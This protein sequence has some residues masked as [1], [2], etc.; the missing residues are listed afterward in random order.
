M[1]NQTTPGKEKLHFTYLPDFARFLLEQKFEVY[2][3]ELLA[4]YRLV[5]FPVMK[6][7]DFMG[8]EKVRELCRASQTKVLTHIRDNKLAAYFEESLEAWRDNQLPLL[9]RDEV[10]AEDISLSS[11]IRKK[12][13]GQFLS[14]YTND[15]NLIIAILA[16]TDEYCLYSET[17]SLNMLLTIQREKMEAANMDLQNKEEQLLQAQQ[18]AN[19]G[20]FEWDLVGKDTYFSPGLQQIF[21]TEAPA[22]FKSFLDYVH[23]EDRDKVNSALE[24][25]L[26]GDGHYECEYRYNKS[27]KEKI[28]WSRGIVSFINGRAYKMTG[29]VAD[30]TEIRLSSIRLQTLNQS[31]LH[32][33]EMLRRSEERNQKMVAE[34]QDY[35]I[36]TLDKNGNVQNWNLGAEKIKGYNADEIIGKNFRIF[37]RSGDIAKDLPGFLLLQ[38]IQNGRATNE[39]YRVRKDGSTFWA[40]VVITALHNNEGE[41]IGFSKVTRD[42]TD[43]KIA[44]DSL[45]KYAAQLKEREENIRHLIDNAP[46]AVVVINSTGE[47]TLWNPEATSIFGWQQEEMV[48]KNLVETIIAPAFRD[49]L[50]YEITKLLTNDDKVRV[51]NTIELLAHDRKGN[52]IPV[53]FTVSVSKQGEE[54]IF[55]AFIRNISEEKRIKSELVRK[56]A[57]LAEL[58]QAL[59]QKN[60]DLEYN[61]QELTSFSYVASHDLQEPLRKIKTFSN[62]IAESETGNMSEKGKELF[63]RINNSTTRMQRL[64]DDLLAFSR[65]HTYNRVFEDVDLN[66]VLTEVK[67]AVNDIVQEPR[68]I[69]DSDKLPVIQGVHFQFYQIFENLIG[70]SLKYARKDIMPRVRIT[71]NLVKGQSVAIPGIDPAASFCEI[72]F[73]DNGIGFE[74][75]HANK[76]F[77]IFQRLHSK[78]EYSGTGIG[79]AICKKIVIN[80]GGAIKAVG[81]PAE[82]ASFFVYLPLHTLS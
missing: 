8:D 82:G 81:H 41:V 52:N 21:E 14:D 55:I 49:K 39:G 35:A 29:T 13:Y 18:I 57:L 51:N 33:N 6:H 56:S 78:D 54:A 72:V 62:L 17:A 43:K 22:S 10:L 76:I 34:V 73:A 40:S 68:I 16:E 63:A 71:C 69:I 37:Y 58:N 74:Q 31:L 2:V 11:Y 50:Y 44:E 67:N 77:E 24:N 27:G 30:I 26:K 36:I 1:T 60:R 38:A 28:I 12:I 23:T 79:L 42:L 70:N 25:A 4:L 46:E 75:K 7:F 59:E 80:H 61:N 15:I 53:Y 48:G 66:I 5:D 32:T 64:I 45:K 65:T 3:T 20:S 9:A 19:M 47:V